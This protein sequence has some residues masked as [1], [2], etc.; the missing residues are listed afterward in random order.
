MS[1]FTIGQIVHHRKFGYRGVITGVDQTFQGTDEWYE[2]VAR[3]R[4]PKDQPW[5]HVL[6]HGATHRTYVAERHL[7]P[8]ASMEPIEH[9]EV[10]EFFD[11]FRDGVYRNSLWN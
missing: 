10:D 9:P 6:V 2:V 8:D 4:P 11:L 5:Y 1:I 3:S 7:E